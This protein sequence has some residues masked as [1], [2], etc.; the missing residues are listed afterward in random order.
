[1]LFGFQAGLSYYMWYTF[2]G[3]VKDV[4]KENEVSMFLL[5]FL[6]T[7]LCPKKGIEINK[8]KYLLITKEVLHFEVNLLLI[9]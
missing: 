9:E 2:A 4:R 6:K 3:K 7:S 5:R 8:K 1:M